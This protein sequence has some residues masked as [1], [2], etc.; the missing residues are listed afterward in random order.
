MFTRF[1]VALIVLV[2]LTILFMFIDGYDEYNK[3]L[4]QF[5]KVNNIRKKY[6]KINLD[7]NFQFRDGILNLIEEKYGYKK[8]DIYASMKIIRCY[9]SK[10]DELSYIA[11]VE[12]YDKQKDKSDL[13]LGL[14]FTD[15][16]YRK[17]NNK[18]LN[19]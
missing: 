16:E 8:H 17:C 6:K 9:R 11:Y 1:I 5:K 7:A 4:H 10:Q 19:S 13:I 3:H 12:T 18:P 2:L 14:P 15:D